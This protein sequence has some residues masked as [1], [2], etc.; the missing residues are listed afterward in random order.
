MNVNPTL[1]RR[2]SAWKELKRGQSVLYAVLFVLALPT[3][4][5]SQIRSSS[6]GTTVVFRWDEDRIT[7]AADT[8][9]IDQDSGGHSDND[10]KISTP[11]QTFLFVTSGY[12]RGQISDVETGKVYLDWDSHQAARDAFKAA[13]T[14]GSGRKDVADVTANW[15]RIAVARFNSIPAMYREQWVKKHKFAGTQVLFA[16]LTDLGKVSASGTWLTFDQQKDV[17]S[18]EAPQT[19]PVGHILLMGLDRDLS[20]EFMNGGTERGRTAM[21]SWRKTVILLSP[22]EQAHQLVIQLL[23]WVILYDQTGEVGGRTTAAEL[24]QSDT[25]RW[26]DPCP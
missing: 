26:I 16:G 18:A 7:V 13:R 14:G 10:C 20:E 17:F 6:T 11:S 12:S 24:R 25:V 1:G 9:S 2:P 22:E 15:A 23:R 19:P 21:E 3:L 5:S 4:A 8:R